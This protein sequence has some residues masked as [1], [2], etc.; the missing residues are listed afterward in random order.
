MAEKRD[1]IIELTALVFGVE[2]D[3]VG[4]PWLAW[5]GGHVMTSKH[6]GIDTRR[7]AVEVNLT[8][9]L[10]CDAQDALIDVLEG[11]LRRRAAVAADGVVPLGG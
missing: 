3:A 1:R 4:I 8:R 7:H 10:E 2:Q 11:V 9:L 6:D 5:S